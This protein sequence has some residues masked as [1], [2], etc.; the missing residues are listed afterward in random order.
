MRQTLA[1]A[2]TLLTL[3]LAQGGPPGGFGPHDHGSYGPSNSIFS[4]FPSC[5]S[6]CWTKV[7]DQC[8]NNNW[9]PDCFCGSSAIS[10]A[11]SCIE[12]SSCGEAEKSGSYQ[13]IAQLCA[14]AGKSVTA[15]P[16]G[17]WSAT[18]GESK[19]WKRFGSETM[20]ARTTLCC[21]GR[22]GPACG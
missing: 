17:T 20:L 12:N 3:C 10:T 6:S 14:N 18:S 21:R 7:Q 1:A 8:N 19:M 9:G 13:T 2:S 5:M 16:E 4:A 22:V 15:S 11:N